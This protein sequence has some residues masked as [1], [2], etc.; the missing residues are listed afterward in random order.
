VIEFRVLG[1]LEAVDEDGP[2]KL[3]AP[4]QRA[5][6]AVLLMHRGEAVSTERLI[7]EIW[8]EQPPGSAN[9]IVQGYVSNLRRVLGGGRLDTRARGYLLHAETGEI[10][11]GRFESLLAEGRRAL[12]GGDPGRAA[13]LLGGALGLWRGAPFADF[14]YA[15]FAQA[16]ISRLEELRLAALEERIE[17]DLSLGDHAGLVGELEA[18][19]SR[20]PLRE[21]LRGQLMLALYRSG[22]QADALAAYREFSELLRE[23]LGLEPGDALQHLE[24][25]I[26]RH[27][28]SLEIAARTRAAGNLPI[29]PTP[30]LGRTRELAEVRT[31]LRRTGTRLL[32]LTGAG[33]SG[34]TRLALRAAE[35]CGEDFKD[36]VWFVALA[37]IVDPG[38][39]IPKICE[40]L[41]LA[42]QPDQTPA[43]RLETYL[44]ARELLLVLDNLEQLAAAAGV[45]GELLARCRGVR[46]LVT[47]REPLHLAGEQQYDVPVL[48]PDDAIELFITR[49]RAVAPA[50]SID[51]TTGAAICERLDRLPLALELAAAR[52]KVLAAGEILA[53]LERRLPVL[54]SGPRDAPRRQQTL[55]ATIDWSYDLLN[56]KQQQL[57]MRLAV[58]VGGCTLQAAET[59]CGADLDTLQSLVDRSLLKLEDGRYRMLQTVRE[60]ALDKLDQSNEAVELR[61]AHAKWLVDLIE[62]EMLDRHAPTTR[63]PTVLAPELENFRSA[64]AWAEAVGQTEVVARLAAPLTWALWERQGR[65]SEAERWLRLAMD[66]HDELPA[67]VQ[68]RVLSA[69]RDVAFRQGDNDKAGVLCEQAL[70]VYR[71]LGDSVSTCRELIS[72][73]ILICDRGDL[74]GARTA[75]EEALAFAREHDVP[76]FVP[77]TLVNLADIAIE[78]GSLEE[79]QA[80]CEEGLSL[81]QDADAASDTELVGLI[82]LAHVANLQRRHCDAAAWG[83]RALTRALERGDL[84]TA[85]SAEMQIA[86]TLAEQGHPERAARLLGAALDLFERSGVTK[87]PTD[88]VSEQAVWNALH[89]QLDERNLRASIDQGRSMSIEE[90]ADSE[91]DAAVDTSNRAY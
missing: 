73:G 37:D 38:L 12:A 80:L 91:T 81:V 77:T 78:E 31:L 89:E 36:G 67:P 18:L 56:G 76:R 24:G 10:D 19:V 48:E 90:A 82:N 54:A 43:Q 33:G 29:P 47:S 5:L 35:G 17:A 26:L 25:A 46:M 63:A 65:L 8:G 30:F 40:A 15:P 88:L 58:F 87:Q 59:V 64:L 32:T 75:L 74:A 28:A 66:A 79:A 14:T 27:D 49:A 51:T 84:L 13:A 21:R 1:S 72:R 9:K 68:G 85:A 20:Y 2:L 16:E 45:L 57:F 69:A 53:R 6:L 70:S 41:G 86:W 22:R 23:E 52:T 39:V 3:G 60:Y 62:A 55:R 61:P 4:K 34:K 44:H 83:Q 42:E 11:V 71:S 7:D 50:A